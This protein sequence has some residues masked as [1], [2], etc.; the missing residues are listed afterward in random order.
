MNIPVLPS[1]LMT[2]FHDLNHYV[3]SVRQQIGATAAAV[4]MIQED[5]VINE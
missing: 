5:K 2:Y 3:E 1:L 4:Y